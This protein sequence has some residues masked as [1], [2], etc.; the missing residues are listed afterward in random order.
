MTGIMMP[1]LQHRFRILLDDTIDPEYTFTQNIVSY[2][3]DYKNK[4]I[5]LVLR[6]PLADAGLSRI[7]TTI[8]NLENFVITMEALSAGTTKPDVIFSN[9]IWCV[10]EKHNFKLSYGEGDAA[11]HYLTLKFDLFKTK[12]FD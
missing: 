7:L 9:E 10:V 1:M 3:A 8:C 4:Q 2:E 6:Q 12:L 5:N 11:Y